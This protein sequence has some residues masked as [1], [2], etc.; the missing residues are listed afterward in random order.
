MNTDEK[1]SHP[2]FQAQLKSRAQALHLA[3][4]RM[5]NADEAVELIY[6]ELKAATLESWKN[7]LQ[8]GRLRATK[9]A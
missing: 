1:K 5:T 2:D 3:L 7:G 6:A 4:G 8:A 9:S